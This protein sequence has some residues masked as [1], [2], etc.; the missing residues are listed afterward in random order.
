M[1]NV[2]FRSI[3]WIALAISGLAFFYGVTPTVAESTIDLPVKRVDPITGEC[4][5]FEVKGSLVRCTDDISRYSE[6]PTFPG[7]TFSYL[8]KVDQSG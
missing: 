7:A 1:P 3:K 5:A 4:V 6:L 2:L 8:Y